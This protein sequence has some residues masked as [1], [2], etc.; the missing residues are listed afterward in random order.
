MT[1]LP[2]SWWTQIRKRKMH[3]MLQA[4]ADFEEIGSVLGCTASQVRYSAANSHRKIGSH[5][6]GDQDRDMEQRDRDRRF[7]AALARA[8]QRGDHL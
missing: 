6:H 5:M 1:A 4:G 8:F 3:H 2:Y 7:V